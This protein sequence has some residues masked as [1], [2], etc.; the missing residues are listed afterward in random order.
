[1]NGG[2][3]PDM[4]KMILA[5]GM[6]FALALVCFGQDSGGERPN[7]NRETEI[8]KL[9]TEMNRAKISGDK[10]M[11][12]Q[13]YADD[14]S[15]VNAIGDITSKD[16]I[17]SFYGSEKGLVSKLDQLLIRVFDKS[18]VVTGR[19]EYRSSA[20]AEKVWLRYTRVYVS[21][22]GAWKAVAEHFSFIKDN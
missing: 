12:E 2:Y 16:Q 21:A 6:F 14:F 7:V 1:M 22:N 5:I 15:G 11:L 10:K 20:N 8:E 17:V 4:R 9:E 3:G 13:L 19:L 18:A